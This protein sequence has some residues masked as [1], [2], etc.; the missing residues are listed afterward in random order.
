MFNPRFPHT[1]VVKRVRKDSTGE[2]VYDANG[3]AIIDTVSLLC[4]EMSDSE[5][6]RDANGSFVTYEANSI[7]FGYRTSAK[8]TT[9]AGDVIVS[10]FRIA[11]PMF[12][13]EILADDILELTDYERSYK[14][15]VVKKTTFN[16]GTSIWFDEVRN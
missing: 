1:L 6:V 7:N 14:G 16:L 11:C 9:T 12:L 3:D 8:N 10:D 13:T 4:V 15:K 2:L 5:P